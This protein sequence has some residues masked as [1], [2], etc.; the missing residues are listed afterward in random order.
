MLIGRRGPL[1]VS[2]TIKELREM[3]TLPGC[4]TVIS[5]EDV[6]GIGDVIEGISQLGDWL[7]L[8]SHSSYTK[9]C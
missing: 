5:P 1:Q 4:R 9:Q 2:F 8:Y 7:K 3:I 6:S